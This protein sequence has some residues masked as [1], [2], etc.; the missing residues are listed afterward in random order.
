MTHDIPTD[1]KARAAWVYDTCA[2]L[3]DSPALG[4]WDRIGTRTVERLSLAPGASALD[5]CCGTGASAIPAAEAVGASGRLLGVDLAEN[6]LRLARAKAAKRGLAHAE[7]RAGDL[8]ALDP[9]AETF[10]AVTCVFG[11]FFLP[12]MA[13]GVRTLWSLVR[14]GGLLAI[15]TWGPRIMEPGASAFWAAVRLERPD[16]YKSFNP[17]DTIQDPAGLTA[18]LREGGISTDD[19]VAE[20]GVQALASADDF[21]TIVLGSGYRG[22]VEQLDAPA[23]E[24]VRQATVG[25]LS[26][27]DVRAVEANAVY[28][29]ARKA[30]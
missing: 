24:R 29:I 18:L 9:A 30:S 5:V 12:N 19:V 3:F 20:S 7:F 15:T 8:E 27:N 28:A 10:D 6:L 22:T 14:P 26:S 23:R 11:I 1:P 2:D 25:H 4:F 17:W 21:W 13:A 16:L